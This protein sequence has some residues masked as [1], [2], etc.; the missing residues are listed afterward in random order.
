MI[1]QVLSVLGKHTFLGTTVRDENALHAALSRPDAGFGDVEAFPT[2]K[3]KA[4]ALAEAILVHHPL[5]DGNKRLAWLMME[6]TF[7]LNGQVW[8]DTDDEKFE[9]IVGLTE[10][11]G[12]QWPHVTTD[13]TLPYD[14]DISEL[15]ENLIEEHSDLFESLGEWGSKGLVRKGYM[16]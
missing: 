5:S 15:A 2:L 11:R 12:H 9:I 1:E 8:S 7:A 13:P 6:I 3:G 14:G 4:L 10:R 16:P